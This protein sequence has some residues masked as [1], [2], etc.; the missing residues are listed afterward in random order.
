MKWWELRGEDVG[1]WGVGDM[2]GSFLGTGGGGQ[3]I[4]WVWILFEDDEEVDFEN[5]K[6][7][8]A[9]EEGRESMADAGD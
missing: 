3:G 7:G 9:V 5:G 6:F 8:K 2:V 4:R 1:A